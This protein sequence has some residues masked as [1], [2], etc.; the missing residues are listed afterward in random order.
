MFAE[1]IEGNGMTTVK[2]PSTSRQRLI[3]ALNHRQPDRIPVD[4]GTSPVPGLGTNR[5]STAYEQIRGGKDL[6]HNLLGFAET[7]R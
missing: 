6:N 1:A 3:E 5:Q 2:A 7:T 4:F